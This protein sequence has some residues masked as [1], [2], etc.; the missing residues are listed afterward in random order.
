[1]MPSGGSYS[2]AMN[3]LSYPTSDVRRL[4]GRLV[5]SASDAPIANKGYIGYARFTLGTFDTSEASRFY[6]TLT[7]T[8]LSGSKPANTKLIFSTV[9][10]FNGANVEPIMSNVPSYDDTIFLSGT[11]RNEQGGAYASDY[12]IPNG[13]SEQVTYTIEIPAAMMRAETMYYL[14]LRGADT[15]CVLGDENGTYSLS[16]GYTT[17]SNNI[18]VKVAGNYIPGHASVKVNGNWVESTEVY[19]KVGGVWK[20]GIA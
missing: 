5:A 11:A 10:A 3:E 4:L 9:D 12:V 2:W 16:V 8:A 19:V 1:M 17:D 6:L 14:Y 18:R 7:M 15:G 20:V 13:T